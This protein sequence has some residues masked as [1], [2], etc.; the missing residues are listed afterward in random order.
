MIE[1]KKHPGPDKWTFRRALGL[2]VILSSIVAA[3]P[4]HKAEAPTWLAFVV[5]FGGIIGG[6]AITGD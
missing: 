5:V 4:L 6:L 1:M 3:L 2:M